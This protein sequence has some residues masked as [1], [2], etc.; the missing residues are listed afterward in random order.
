L[1]TIGHDRSPHLRRNA[2]TSG[3]ARGNRLTLRGYLASI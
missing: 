2:E 1:S 3:S